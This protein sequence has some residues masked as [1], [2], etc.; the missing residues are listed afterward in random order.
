MT[1]PSILVATV[2]AILATGCASGGGI[3]IG[4]NRS[5]CMTVSTL[6]GGVGGV[7]VGSQGEGETDERLVGASL[8]AL[9]GA[10]LGALVCGEGGTVEIAQWQP[11]I[12]ASPGDGIAPLSVVLEARMEP[13]EA[14]VKTF[15]WDLGDGTRASG[16]R[17]SHTY[18][19]PARFD[20]R[21]TATNGEGER[22]VATARIDVRPPDVAAAPVSTR[23]VLRG[24]NFAFA[25]AEISSQDQAV[26]DIAAEQLRDQPARR[27]RVVGHTDAVGTD[28]YNLGLSERRA[29]A[30]LGYLVAEGVNA[31]RLDAE[32]RGESEP[33][34]A[35]DAAQ[36]RR[37]ELDV[38]E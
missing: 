33:L 16:A 19:S 14:G 31:T 29:A 15:E 21:L 24:V 7:V 1:Q 34:S 37:V 5:T 28:A 13:G 10:A 4:K 3:Q 6:L 18:R 38:I 30:V 25:S 2:L 9:T 26:L 12:D 22:R 11:T 36:N 35:D 27:V 23:I 32:G 8:G 20:V 17:V